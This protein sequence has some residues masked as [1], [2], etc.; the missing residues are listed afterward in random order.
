[1]SGGLINTKGTKHISQLISTVRVVAYNGN[2]VVQ[3]RLPL[4]QG[5]FKR[6]YGVDKT[7]NIRDDPFENVDK[8]GNIDEA[9]AFAQQ[10][11][12]DTSKMRHKMNK[13]LKNGNVAVTYNIKTPESDP[14]FFI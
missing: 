10:F 13:R 12:D 7:S 9:E 8:W 2:F 3:A 6:W 14:E 5:Y 1:M 11:I 4:L